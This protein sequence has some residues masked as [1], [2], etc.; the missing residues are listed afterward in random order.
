MNNTSETPPYLVV[1]DLT[2]NVKN[3][4]TGLNE[5]KV[6]RITTNAQNAIK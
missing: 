2:I 4:E 1:L 5:D 3:N 6:I